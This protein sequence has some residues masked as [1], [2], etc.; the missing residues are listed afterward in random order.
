MSILCVLSKACSSFSEPCDAPRYSCALDIPEYRTRGGL[1]CPP[2]ENWKLGITRH[3]YESTRV[4]PLVSAVTK[5]LKLAPSLNIL[6]CGV[7]KPSSTCTMA[8]RHLVLAQLSCLLQ[9][10]GPRHPPECGERYDC[11]QAPNSLAAHHT[12]TS[13]SS[14]VEQLWMVTARAR[15]PPYLQQRYES[16][17]M[18]RQSRT[19]TDVSLNARRAQ[20]HGKSRLMS[21]TGCP[22]PAQYRGSD[23]AN[24]HKA[25]DWWDMRAGIIKAV[26]NPHYVHWR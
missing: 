22:F 26:P 23:K 16:C 4:L 13:R 2:K 8:T 12:P 10:P 9:Y 18:S 7:A 15:A 20:K 25:R 21:Q 19:Q 14:A 6:W 11:I 3:F 5:M 1:G 24:L 17:S